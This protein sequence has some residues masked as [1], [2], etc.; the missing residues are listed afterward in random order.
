MP[1]QFTDQTQLVKGGNQ[2]QND[3]CPEGKSI[4]ILYIKIIGR[5]LTFSHFN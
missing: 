3:Q 1:N 5:I 2:Q 4:I